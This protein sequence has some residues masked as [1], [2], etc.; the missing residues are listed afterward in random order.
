[1]VN[2]ALVVIGSSLLVFGV[3]GA[4]FLYPLLTRPEQALI[5]S[6]DAL[7]NGETD[8]VNFEYRAF[9][10]PDG[11]LLNDT[12]VLRIANLGTRDANDI[13]ITLDH[14]PKTTDWY[15]LLSS[16]KSFGDSM[17][18]LEGKRVVVR[19]LEIEST[20]SIRF[21]VSMNMS[22]IQVNNALQD[23]SQLIF[24]IT[25]DEALIPQIKTY[26]VKLPP[27]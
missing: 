15:T 14:E 7:M 10:R 27:Q 25:N 8:D 9:R 22:L 12:F 20:V 18:E 17:V 4:A 11:D 16:E 23:K 2:T 5:V 26:N 6:V 13:V 24:T 21:T 19:S 3:A 1:M